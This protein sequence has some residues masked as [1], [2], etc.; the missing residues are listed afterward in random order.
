MERIYRLLYN[1]DLYLCAYGRIAKNAGALTPGVTEETID[2]MSLA[3]IDAIIAAIRTERYRWKPARRVTI[4]KPHSTK[5]RPLGLPTWSDKLVQEVMRM[6]LDAYYD[7]QFSP[8]SHGFRQGRGCHTA[9]KEM[10]RTWQGT[11][12]FIEGDIAQCFDRLDH[13]YLMSIL[14]EQI[15]DGRFL[16]LI[17]GLLKAGYLEQ[18]TFHSSLS[19]VPQGS[20]L[21][22]LLSN[23][24]LDRLDQYVEQTLLPQ[25][26]QKAK[27]RRNRE[28]TRLEGTIRRRKKH[29][30]LNE[31]AR[32]KA[33]L[34][35]LPSNDPYDP[36]Y[37]RL[38]YVRYADDFLLGFTGPRAEAEAITA[39]LRTYLAET[40]HLELSAAKTKITHGRTDAAAF[41][42]YHVVVYQDDT[43][44][45]DTGR[46][47]I[48]A[49]I[50][51]RVPPTVLQRQRCR[52][53]R[54]GK[55]RARMECISNSDFSIVAQYQQ[56]FRG[57]VNY[58]RHAY[59]LSKDLHTVEW[60]MEQSLVHT[61]ARK[62]RVS[63]RR[64][65]HRYTT[66]ITEG[67]TTT[68]VLQVTI[69]R[70]GKPPLVAQWGGISLKW[71][72][73]AILDDTPSYVW[74]T[75]TELA[76]RLLAQTCELCGGRTNIEVHHIRALK[77]LHPRGRKARPRW[78]EVMAARRRKSLVVCTACHDDIHAGR[79]DGRRSE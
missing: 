33:I 44:R 40:L 7:P 9:L 79:A 30:H 72:H 27:R 10:T 41:L 29:G 5:R 13:A 6:I 78:M 68:K 71:D 24:Y 67:K 14:R 15:H 52:Y 75:R 45:D 42:G 46:R 77:T 53:M 66:R 49:G 55:P 11:T 37:R 35:T 38:H 76:E 32:L 54:N 31:A 50:G 21:G 22:P 47:S 39:T 65:Y 58:Y 1:R 63:C 17:E 2:S 36:D 23:I 18:W 59:N 64:I 12:W 74:N 16:R 28:Y 60:M 61:L 57:L 26:N 51:F 43:K 25:Y 56:E 19:G 20:I 73:R 48:N 8:R 3:K 4:P 34:Q 70:E 69:P 62:F